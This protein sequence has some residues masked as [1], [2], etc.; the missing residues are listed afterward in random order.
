MP[1]HVHLLFALSRTLAMS[2]VVEEVKKGSSKWAKEHVH[3]VFYW[4]SGY[5][6]FAVSSDDVPTA[7][8]YVATQ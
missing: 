3:P 5:G 1:D 6:I 4:Q 2:K 8:E 7:R